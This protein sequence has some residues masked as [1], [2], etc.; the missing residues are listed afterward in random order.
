MRFFIDNNLSTKLA[1]G[2][3]AFGEAVDHLKD[4]FPEDAQDTEWLAYIGNREFFLITRDD[5]IRRNPAEIRA[6]RD[7]RVGAFFLGGKNRSRC[8]L[9]QQL[10]RNWPRIK[11]IAHTESRPFAF[12]VPPSGK[13]FTKITLR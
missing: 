11:E 1:R 4:H 3:S 12:R 8:Q 6:L 7:H 5:N 10:V 2:M 13:K 9:I